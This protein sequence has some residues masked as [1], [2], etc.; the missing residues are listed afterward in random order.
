[1]V[2]NVLL[3]HTR[4]S[5]NMRRISG[6]MG[7]ATSNEGQFKPTGF[8][9]YTGVSADI[10]RLIVVFL[11]AAV[12]DQIRSNISHNR[13]FTFQ[14]GADIDKALKYAGFN[15]APLRPLYRPLTAMARRRN[16]IVH[17]TDLPSKSTTIEPWGVVDVWSLT[18]WNLTVLAF[19]FKLMEVLT[20]Q[21]DVFS[22][23]YDG[24]RKAMDEN[25]EYAKLLMNFPKVNLADQRAALQ[26][27]ADKLAAVMAALEPVRSGK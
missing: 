12:E 23:R 27:M 26:A 17:E 11:H 8:M 21:H 10:F 18:Q 13:T 9:T 15:A 25:I 24:A 2:D 4:F 5:H 3:S 14:S 1:V 19:H 6:L 20:I 22:R 16:R 7:L